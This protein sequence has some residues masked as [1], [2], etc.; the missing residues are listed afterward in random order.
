MEQVTDTQHV[1]NRIASLPDFLTSD[2]TDD[3]QPF[4]DFTVCL[5][6][7]GHEANELTIK[8]YNGQDIIT[9]GSPLLLTAT[10][11][12]YSVVCLHY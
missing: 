11:W 2:N 6:T 10:N 12:P 1:I 4:R 3:Y 8:V 5:V 9:M 7:S